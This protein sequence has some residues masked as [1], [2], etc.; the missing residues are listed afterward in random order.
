[1][2]FRRCGINGCSGAFP[3]LSSVAENDRFLTLT[4]TD[5]GNS[6]AGDWILFGNPALE[7]VTSKSKGE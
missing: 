3:I 6:M 1:V 2:R 4:A 5:S 7:M